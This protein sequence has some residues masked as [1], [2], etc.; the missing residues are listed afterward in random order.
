M[1]RKRALSAIIYNGKVVMVK[2]EEK[3]RNFWTIPGENIEDV[4]TP[5]T[6]IGKEMQ[7]HSG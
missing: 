2:T 1:N 6:F 3:T 5:D 4:E 7:Q